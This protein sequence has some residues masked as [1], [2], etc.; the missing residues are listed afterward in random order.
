MELER[1]SEDG[2][3]E[4]LF[5]HP[6]EEENLL[7]MT[8]CNSVD[9]SQLRKEVVEY[10]EMLDKLQK[11]RERNEG[12]Y[13][14]RKRLDRDRIYALHRK[15]VGIDHRLEERS[16]RGHSRAGKRQSTGSFGSSQS[17]DRVELSWFGGARRAEGPSPLTLNS[18]PSELADEEEDE[19]DGEDNKAEE[20]PTYVQAI[21]MQDEEEDEED[22]EDNKAEENPT[23]V[24]A[25]MD[26]EEDEEDGEDNKAEENPT[27]VQAWMDE[28]EDEEDG[29]D[30]K[31]EENPTYVQAW[32]DEEEDEEDGE[33]NKAEENPTYVQA[34]MDE[35][36]DEEDGEEDNKKAEENPNICAG[37]DGATDCVDCQ[38]RLFEDTPS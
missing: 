28:E 15:K 31:A 36:E 18:V 11:V 33:D 12:V 24:Q 37:M 16:I 4:I 2:H 30:N 17:M 7:T 19:E 6:G 23:Y 5:G 10:Q 27:Y 21:R 26:E 9:R 35:E 3:I 32:M 38:R 29:E 14:M 34:W 1:P 20:N 25:W 22:A 8:I 13:A